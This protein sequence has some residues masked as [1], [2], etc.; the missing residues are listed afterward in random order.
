MKT[1]IIKNGKGHDILIDDKFVM[2]VIGSKKN[3]Q[4]ELDLLL[5]NKRK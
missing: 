1:E 3:A 4:K 2:W 5:K